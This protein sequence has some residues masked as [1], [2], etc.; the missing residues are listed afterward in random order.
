MS[1][2]AFTVV[3]PRCDSDVAEDGMAA[4]FN[5]SVGKSIHVCEIRTMIRSINPDQS[6]PTGNQGIMSIDRISSVVGGA[7]VAPIKFDTSSSDLPSQVKLIQN[8]D[9]VSITGTPFRCF[10]DCISSYTI[11]KQIS[12]QAMLRAPNVIDANDHSGRTSES[13]D[14]WHA[15]GVSVTEP[16][17]LREGEGLSITRREYGM[18]QAM[19]FSMTVRVVST[20]KTY[21]YSDGDF[22]S[23][24]EKGMATLALINGSGSGIV[25]QVMIISFPDLGEENIPLYRIVRC[26]TAFASAD[27]SGTSVP[28]VAHD[29]A[30]TLT[31]VAAYRG[32][33]RIL[34]KAADNGIPVT[35][36]DYQATPIAIAVQQQI[37][38]FRKFLGAGPYISDTGTVT[39]DPAAIARSEYDVWPGDRRGMNTGEDQHVILRPGEGIAIIGGGS[40]LIETSEQAYLDVE[41]TGYLEDL[42]DP[43]EIAKAVWTTAG[44]TLTA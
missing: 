22:G 8:P 4:L 38:C 10:G 31:E 34:P 26:S 5:K 40:G 3:F 6:N 18:T 37:D 19:H 27:F 32:P 30:N 1:R 24:L 13:Q 25:L 41:M 9:S 12:F 14:V 35:Y 15:D 17:V 28:V 43:A 33:M 11:L 2:K 29:T 21:R 44:R 23:S 42:A 36:H 16:I 20:G 39:L 7:E